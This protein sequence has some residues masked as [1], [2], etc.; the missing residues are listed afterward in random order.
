VQ[1]FSAVC[2]NVNWQDNHARC[3][4]TRHNLS[5]K[6]KIQEREGIRPDQMRIL[7]A[8]EQL[9]DERTMGDYLIGRE[10]TL[11]LMLRLRGGMHH[12]SS[13]GKKGNERKGKVG[14]K[15]LLEV[16]PKQLN[17]EEAD[18]GHVDIDINDGDGDHEDAMDDDEEDSVYDDEDDGEDE[19]CEWLD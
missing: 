8:G 13:T 3:K 12:D 7:F 11:H 5:F 4:L 9:E 14:G 19:I 6:A 10:C 17:K 1:L 18:S 2:E 16:D 15:R